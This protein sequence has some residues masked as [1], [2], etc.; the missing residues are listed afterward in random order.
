ME[1]LIKR[2]YRAKKRPSGHNITPKFDKDRGGSIP[3]NLLVCGNN[4]SNGAYLKACQA[5]G[6]KP[7]PARF[8]PALPRFF[9]QFLTSPGDLVLD[10]FAGSNTTGAVCEQES[11]R[12]LACELREEYLAGSR[13]KF[14]QF[15]G[16]SSE[17]EAAAEDATGLPLFRK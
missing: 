15:G 12:W 7:H 2:G 16:I 5:A 3:A 11:R 1:R 13:F 14:R 8:P 17:E 10:P 4:D 6:I 9:V